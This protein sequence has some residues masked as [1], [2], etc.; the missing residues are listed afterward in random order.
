MGSYASKVE[1][2]WKTSKGSKGFCP[3][4]VSFAIAI[5]VIKNLG[6]PLMTWPVTVLS[7]E[8]VRDER[9]K[10]FKVSLPN[11]IKNPAQHGQTQAK[12]SN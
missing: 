6:K 1:M 2:S 3:L 12:T 9:K 5:F 7:M 11:A 4:N 8:V 10:A